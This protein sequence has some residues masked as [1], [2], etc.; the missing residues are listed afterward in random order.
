M[1]IQTKPK[2]L[3]ELVEIAGIQL[4][5][6]KRV[7]VSECAATDRFMDGGLGAYKGMWKN[8]TTPYLVEPMNVLTDLEFTEMIFIGSAQTGKTDMAVNAFIYNVLH[9]PKDFMIL[10]PSQRSAADFSIKKIARALRDNPAIKAGLIARK[11]NTFSKS[12]QN[13]SILDI[14]WP[15]ISILSSKTLP[16]IW[17]SDLDRGTMNVDGEGHPF[18]LARTRTTI[19]ES[20]GMTVAETTPGFPVEDSKWVADPVKFGVSHQAPPCK[21]GLALYNGGDR[22]RWYWPCANCGMGFEPHVKHFKYNDSKDLYER[23]ASVA[24]A[25]PHCGVLYRHNGAMDGGTTMPSKAEMNRR[26]VWL[27]EG[28]VLDIEGNI[29][30][31]GIVSKRATFWLNGAAAFKKDW[32]TIAE[33]QFLAEEEYNNGGDEEALKVT[34]NTDQGIP[35]TPISM[36]GSRFPEELRKRAEDW[37]D[38]VVPVDA[39]FL[40]ASVDVQHHRFEVQVHGIGVGNDV[41][42]IDRFSIDHS[43]RPDEREG[44]GDD[45]FHLLDPFVQKR[46]WRLLLSEVIAKKY[47]LAGDPSRVMSIYMTICDSGGKDNTTYNAYEFWRWLRYGPKESDVDSDDWPEWSSDLHRRFQL[48]K[49][50]HRGPRTEMKFPDRKGKAKGAD[51][52]GEIPVLFANTNSVKNMLDFILM[53]PD[54]GTGM[55]HFP[56]WLDLSF[57]KELCAEEKD[58][59]GNWVKTSGRAK[60]ESWDLLSMLYALLFEPT[61]IGIERIVDWDKP[62]TFALPWDQNPLITRADQ[63]LG[64]DKGLDMNDKMRELGRKS[65]ERDDE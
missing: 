16:M 63:K 29:V 13:G 55:I 34:L 52:R 11:D 41:W 56:D 51:A 20:N 48:F 7:S 26:G 3:V 49:G 39:R 50:D 36:Q 54:K 23:A 30:G 43:L 2:S 18:S 32:Q 53:R 47:P 59:K 14:G 40:V 17:L 27:K 22:R 65:R 24:M 38:R 46:D 44:A 58:P 21:G 12:F 62:P 45:A 10:L 31:K 25:C 1:K 35:Y 8:E 4:L 42:V 9:A 6:P 33:N 15:T 64:I 57:Y 5:P 60:N 61:R 28:Q 37:G 19:Y